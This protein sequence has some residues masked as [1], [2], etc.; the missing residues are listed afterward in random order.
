VNENDQRATEENYRLRRSIYCHPSPKVQQSTPTPTPRNLSRILKQRYSLAETIRAPGLRHNSN[1]IDL[2]H[3]RR[4]LRA[5]RIDVDTLALRHTDRILLAVLREQTP[6]VVVV[7]EAIQPGA[8]DEDVRA[9]EQI[10]A[11]RL[12]ADGDD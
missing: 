4:S 7:E 6:L 1:L 11:V 5:Q 8:V 2:D 3:D 12:V 9:I 10:E